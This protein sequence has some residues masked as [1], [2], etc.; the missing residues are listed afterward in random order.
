MVPSALNVELDNDVQPPAKLGKRLAGI[1]ELLDS[2][3]AC[4]LSD[5]EVAPEP[6]RLELFLPAHNLHPSRQVSSPLRMWR[7]SQPQLRRTWTCSSARPTTS[8]ALFLP[9]DRT[10]TTTGARN[11]GGRQGAGGQMRR[12]AEHFSGAL[13]PDQ[14]VLRAAEDMVGA[15]LKVAKQVRLRAHDHRGKTLGTTCLNDIER[16]RRRHDCVFDHVLCHS[17]HMKGSGRRPLAS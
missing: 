6:S 1:R 3:G 9:P 13:G 4:M 12:N 5:N 7:P 17:V 2:L 10:A 14:G 11:T 8:P 16:R 15:N